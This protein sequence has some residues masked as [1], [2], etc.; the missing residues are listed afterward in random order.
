MT[1][2]PQGTSFKADRFGVLKVARR[3][4]RFRTEK[5]GVA[6]IE[7][8]LIAPFMIALW[9][10]SIELS[11]GVSVDRKVTHAA[12]VLADLVTQQNNVTGQELRDI[13]DATQAIM[14]PFDVSRLTIQIAGVRINGDG[15]TEV[16]WS[17]ARNGAAPTVG[18]TYSIPASLL[19]PNSFLVV[20]DLTYAHRPSTS[21][22][23]T[24]TINL[25]DSFFLRPRRSET[26]TY[27]P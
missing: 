26:I 2:S 15:A 3:I 20:A 6:A 13:M 14:M 22:V 4:R 25:S 11:Q 23:I 21:H 19:I 10:G 5:R 16:M 12:S 8:T 7:F 27:T 18:G 1:K 17:E 24:G 9:L